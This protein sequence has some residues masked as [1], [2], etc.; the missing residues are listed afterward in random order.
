MGIILALFAGTAIMMRQGIMGKELIAT[1]DQGKFML[2]LEF[3]KSTALKENNLHSLAVERYLL[4][5]RE[6]ASVFS[7]VGGPST[8]IGSMGVGA[9]NKTELTISLVP[10]DEREGIRTDAYMKDVREALQDSFPGI[11]FTMS[12]IGLIPRTAPV[13]ITLSGADPAQL[14]RTANTLKDTLIGIPGANNVRLSIEAEAP[15]C[16]WNWTT[17]AWPGD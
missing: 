7:N 8:G 6:V 2:A 9:E 1:G 5:Q 10:N 4:A 12:A 17:T 3:D 15:N 14:M 16:R 13:E 11:D